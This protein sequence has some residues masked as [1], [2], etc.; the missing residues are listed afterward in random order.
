MIQ[1]PEI[2]LENG[3]HTKMVVE[4]QIRYLKIPNHL[5]I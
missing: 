5:S 4:F 1:Q 2:Q 3:Q